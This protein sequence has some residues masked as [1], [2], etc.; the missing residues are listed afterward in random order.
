MQGGPYYL[1]N[2][3]VLFTPNLRSFA[4]LGSPFNRILESDI[5]FLEELD[6]SHYGIYPMEPDL[7]PMGW[8][9]LYSD[10]KSMTLSSY[11]FQGTFNGV[12]EVHDF[13]L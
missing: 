6:T 5:S 7:N 11:V 4:F 2:G 9:Q 1:G 8:F 13:K 3:I 12:F 10:V